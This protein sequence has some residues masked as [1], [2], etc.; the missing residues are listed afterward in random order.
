MRPSVIGLLPGRRN[1]KGQ[2][3]EQENRSRERFFVLS[4]TWK[5][6]RQ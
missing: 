5:R 2:T 4:R 1:K 3:T 6:L